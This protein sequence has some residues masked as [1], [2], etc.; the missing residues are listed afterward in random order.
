LPQ[1]IDMPNSIKK[2]FK[3]TDLCVSITLLL[4]FT[5]QSSLATMIATESILEYA[6]AVAFR[7]PGL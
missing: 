3:S 6:D 2:R 4:A 7:L 5:C 1:K